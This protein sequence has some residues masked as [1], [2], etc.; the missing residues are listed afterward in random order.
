MATAKKADKPAADKIDLTPEM[1]KIA[2]ALFDLG[3]D[4]A[5]IPKPESLK[6][7]PLATLVAKKIIERTENTGHGAGATP[8]KV[9]LLITKEQI[10]SNATAR[11]TTPPGSSRRTSTVP[12]AL[13]GVDPSEFVSLSNLEAFLRDLKAA[14]A[15]RMG[16]R[17]K[18]ASKKVADARKAVAD[19][20]DDTEVDRAATNLKTA[21][22]EKQ[23]LVDIV[24][25]EVAKAMKKE[26]T[27]K[28]LGPLYEAMSIGL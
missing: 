3:A 23:Q 19:A 5:P 9:R 13:R 25:R 27:S 26:D 15:E 10:T 6:G 14:V 22:R 16:P 1:Y 8:G 18:E 24:T 17:E 7:T 12:R 21:I 28:N 2:T 20:G 11:T 4:K